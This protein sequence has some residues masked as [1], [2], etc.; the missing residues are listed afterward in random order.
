MSIT[1]CRL[2]KSESNLT[3]LGRDIFSWISRYP[4][5]GKINVLGTGRTPASWTAT[6]DIGGTYSGENPNAELHKV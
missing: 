1:F 5:T 4:S 6:E 2:E 3:F